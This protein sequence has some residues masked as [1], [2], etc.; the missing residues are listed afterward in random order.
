MCVNRFKLI[1]IMST[2]LT[3]T[4]ILH[5]ILIRANRQPFDGKSNSFL[6]SGER[7]GV[8]VMVVE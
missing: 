3:K 4:V 6:G 5:Y 1:M 8:L 7:D 2:F